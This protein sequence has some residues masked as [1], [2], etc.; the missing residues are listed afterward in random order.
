[1][2]NQVLER[3]LEKAETQAGWAAPTVERETVSD[4]HGAPPVTRPGTMTMGGVASAT[5]VLLVVL[6]LAGAVGWNL[7]EE[8]VPGEVE[9][10]GWILL[11]LLAAFGVAIVTMFR[12]P[13]AR[14][15]APVYAVLEGLVLGAISRVFE[16]EWNGIVLQAV[17]LTALVLAVMAFLY[18]TRILKVTDRMRRVIIGA[19]LAICVFY[20][21]S[22]LLALFGAT[23]PLIWD[24]GPLGILFSLVVCGIAAFNLVLDFDLAERGVQAGLPKHMEWYC[25]FGL[26][27]SLVWLYLEM[28]RLLSKLRN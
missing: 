1:M 5:A 4:W 25:G 28:L 7:V 17:M 19:T 2:A 20:M 10:P 26:I 21:V 14:F 9:F 16:E 23:M 3:G 18:G 15:T 12:P 24:S 22:L 11:P 27:V 8:P 13:I 6:L